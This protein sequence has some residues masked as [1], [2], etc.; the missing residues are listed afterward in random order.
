M[1]EGTA[2]SGGV[3]WLVMKG[4]VREV[5]GMVRVG[6]GLLVQVGLGYGEWGWYGEGWYRVRGGVE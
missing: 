5:G 2:S 1:V 6:N 3:W 4:R